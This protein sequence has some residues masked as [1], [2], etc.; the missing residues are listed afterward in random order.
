MRFF[1]SGHARRCFLKENLRALQKAKGDQLVSRAL[2][3]SAWQVAQIEGYSME[4]AT[5]LV[6]TS[7]W[8]LQ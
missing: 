1:N 3:I 7:I 2:G 4:C 8:Q 6:W 5:S